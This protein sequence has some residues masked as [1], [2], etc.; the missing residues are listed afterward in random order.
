MSM[1]RKTGINGAVGVVDTADVEGNPHH[2]AVATAPARTVIATTIEGTSKILFHRYDCSSVEE[3]G[4]AAKGSK[5]KK[6]DDVASYLYRDDAG[7]LGIPADAIHGCL[8]ASAKSFQDPRSPRKSAADL[9]RA[10]LLILPDM[11]RLS[12]DRRDLVDPE[13]TDTRRVR[14]QLNAISRTRPGLLNGWR[15]SFDAMI[16]LPD[17]VSPELYRTVLAN[18]GAIVG[19]CDFRPRFGRF[20]VVGADRV[21]L[22]D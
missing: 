10:G 9:F 14:V 4:K 6:S 20:Q 13:F 18:A 15:L 11:P 22:T 17:Y 3:K 2:N 1:A 16:L 7:Y 12:R 21:I 5:A 8:I 19:L